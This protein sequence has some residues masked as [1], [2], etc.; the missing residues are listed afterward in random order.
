[1]RRNYLESQII[2]NPIECVQKRSPL[3]SQSH[4][5]LILE[6]EPIHIDEAKQDKN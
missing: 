4:T 6:V 5:A 3:R 1:M 2:G